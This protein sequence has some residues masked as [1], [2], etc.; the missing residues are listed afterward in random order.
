M[1]WQGLSA[2][3]SWASLMLQAGHP[4]GSADMHVRGAIQE[5]VEKTRR[6]LEPAQNHAELSGDAR[7]QGRKGCKGEVGSSFVLRRANAILII[8][9][10]QGRFGQGVGGKN[11][12]P[13]E[14]MSLVIGKANVETGLMGEARV[15]QGH[16]ESRTG[17][18]QG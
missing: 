18:T 12:G 9:Q 7:V 11:R 3:E 4:V 6:Q 10:S 15:D 14:G 5:L 8:M 1:E 16:L 13:E 17:M 2:M